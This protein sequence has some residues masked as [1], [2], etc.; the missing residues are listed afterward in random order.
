MSLQACLE[1]AERTVAYSG[2]RGA[3]A[4]CVMAYSFCPPVNLCGSYPPP[5]FTES[6]RHAD[7]GR[8]RHRA[9]EDQGRG[10][11]SS[12]R[13]T[14][15]VGGRRSGSG[16]AWKRDAGRRAGGG[17]RAVTR[18]NTRACSDFDSDSNHCNIFN[19]RFETLQVDQMFFAGVL[20]STESPSIVKL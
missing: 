15:A 5:P 1:P 10:G 4:R 11:G 14:G 8:A 16:N 7:G 9:G 3:R 19:F 13:S 18:N 6:R 2:P 20:Y 12:S 17:R